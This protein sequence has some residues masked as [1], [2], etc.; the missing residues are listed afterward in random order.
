MLREVHRRP[1]GE[2]TRRRVGAVRVGSRPFTIIRR[3]QSSARVHRHTHIHQ[4]AIR[5]PLARARK[6]VNLCRARDSTPL[7]GPVARRRP[8]R[9]FDVPPR[10]PKV[11]GTALLPPPRRRN[12]A[13][14]SGQNAVFFSFNLFSA[15]FFKFFFNL[16]AKFPHSDRQTHPDTYSRI[17]TTV[18]YCTR[19]VASC[20]ALGVMAEAHTNHNNVFS[21]RSW[22]LIFRGNGRP[23]ESGANA[24][25]VFFAQPIDTIS[26]SRLSYTHS[27]FA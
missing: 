18:S 3:A 5:P 1:R 25:V 14:V 19:H 22:E 24:A 9:R 2:G 27:V 23:L 13:R 10:A 11:P 6:L 20:P 15:V 26:S 12:P 21:V 4:N 16:A 17:S 8:L 7:L